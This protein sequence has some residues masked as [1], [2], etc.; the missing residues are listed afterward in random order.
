MSVVHSPSAALSHMEVDIS[1]MRR[2]IREAFEKEF[3]TGIVREVQVAWNN[4]DMIDVA[5]HVT[6]KKEGLWDTCLR[7]AEELQRWGIRAALRP[8]YPV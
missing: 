3:G 2:Y 7:V 6:V 8:D 4:P 1:E 5:V